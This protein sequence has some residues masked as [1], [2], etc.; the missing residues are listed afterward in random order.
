MSHCLAT[1]KEKQMPT[2]Y[3]EDYDGE[4]ND[5]AVE[6]VDFH[7]K[8]VDSEAASVED[9]AVKKSASKRKS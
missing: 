2:Y 5:D 1:T 4:R 8:V 3:A 9:K 7:S 6:P